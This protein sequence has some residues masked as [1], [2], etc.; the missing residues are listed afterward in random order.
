MGLRARRMQIAVALGVLMLL[1]AGAAA[2][3]KPFEVF[4]LSLGSSVEAA[5][6]RYPRMFFQTTPYKDDRVGDRYKNFYGRVVPAKVEGRVAYEEDTR[7]ITIITAF[8]G[9]N[10]LYEAQ[11]SVR[12]EAVDCASQAARLTRAHGEPASQEADRFR[13][14]RQGQIGDLQTLEFRCYPGEGYALA[15]RD[16][17]ALNA[18]LRKTAATLEPYILQELQRLQ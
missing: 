5:Q 3:A 8:T 16:E 13:L 4:G 1:A 17:D 10:A 15:M 9:A 2:A 11:A 18:Y 14:W 7:F 12:D 6:S